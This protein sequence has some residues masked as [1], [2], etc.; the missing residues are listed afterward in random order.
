MSYSNNQGIFYVGDIRINN[1]KY[2]VKISSLNETE[3]EIKIN[4]INLMELQINKVIIT[5][6]LN[7]KIKLYIPIFRLYLTISYSCDCGF[8][9]GLGLINQKN[10]QQH[11]NPLKYISFKCK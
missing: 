4:S 5:K 2:E 1:N 3:L 9:I 7:S 8:K 11:Q 6:P 10:I